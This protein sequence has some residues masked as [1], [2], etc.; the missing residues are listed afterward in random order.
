MNT[1]QEKINEIKALKLQADKKLMQLERSF[2]IESLWPEAFVFGSVSS[3]FHGSPRA[4]Y[5]FVIVR[6]DGSK[7]EFPFADVPAILK[8]TLK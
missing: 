2:A 1:I 6:G 3:S 8:E 7:K 4:G 5:T